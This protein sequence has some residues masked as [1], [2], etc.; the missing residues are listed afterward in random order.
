M[1]KNEYRRMATRTA[2]VPELKAT[3]NHTVEAVGGI[4][5]DWAL[6]S[7][8]L[9]EEL[10]KLDPDHKATFADA[11]H[12]DMAIKR[13][14]RGVRHLRRHGEKPPLLHGE[15]LAANML[16]FDPRPKQA[17]PAVRPR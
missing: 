5:V 13:D 1:R 9:E 11:H 10:D 8:K 2:A 14:R 3:N 4:G 15:K 16:E 6:F 7:A 12:E 17:D